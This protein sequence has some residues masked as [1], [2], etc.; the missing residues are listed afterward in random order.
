MPLAQLSNSLPAKYGE[1]FWNEMLR[2]N[3]IYHLYKPNRVISEASSESICLR[4][5]SCHGSNKNTTIDYLA[6]YATSLTNF[7]Y[8]LDKVDAHIPATNWT[9][10]MI[11][12]IETLVTVS[13]LIQT[14]SRCLYCFAE[15]DR[16]LDSDVPRW[17]LLYGL[18][19]CNAPGNLSNPIFSDINRSSVIPTFLF[20]RQPSN[21]SI[22]GHYVSLLR[23]CHQQAWDKH[24]LFWDAPA[25]IPNDFLP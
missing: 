19:S 4:V 10:N 23:N 15:M 11:V 3:R 7:Q 18:S 8:G 12:F 22:Q 13:A 24:V 17:Q 16:P 25:M 1:A 5:H 14:R 20:C 9:P 21:Q 2:C 6:L